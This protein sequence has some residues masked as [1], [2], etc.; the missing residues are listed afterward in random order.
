MRHG[1][2]DIRK[3]PI[4]TWLMLSVPP[5]I[6][7]SDMPLRMRCAATEIAS[8]PEAQKRFTVTP[9]TVSGKPARWQAM[10]AIFI[11]CAPSG[12]AQ[13]RTKSSTWSAEICGTR[14]RAPLMASAARSS[15][16]TVRIFPFGALPT[17]VRAAATI[18]ASFIMLIP[19][20]LSRLECVLDARDRLWF[21]AQAQKRVPFQVHDVLL[22]DEV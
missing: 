2:G 15:G 14:A 13:P 6:T 8:R 21:A 5:A 4:G 17:G 16:R 12:M 11:P 9:G 10:R 22:R 18:K 7:I 3:P 1:L 19:Q 20:W